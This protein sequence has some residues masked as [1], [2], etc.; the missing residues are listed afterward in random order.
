MTVSEE[1]F[2]IR[3]HKVEFVLLFVDILVAWYI[4][5]IVKGTASLKRK[6]WLYIRNFCVREGKKKIQNTNRK[7]ISDIRSNISITT[8]KRMEGL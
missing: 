7:I 8:G 1:I 6:N 4:S 2:S 3:E 5:L